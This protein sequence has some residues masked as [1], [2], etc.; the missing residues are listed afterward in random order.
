MD[1]EDDFDLIPGLDRH[2]PA[3][4]ARRRRTPWWDRLSIYLP[5]I[6]MGV[7]ALGVAPADSPTIDRRAPTTSPNNPV[8]GPRVP[9]ASVTP[10]SFDVRR[11]LAP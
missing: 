9:A 1:A 7:L 10:A 5:V 2:V 11:T 8:F 6:L 3:T 4:P